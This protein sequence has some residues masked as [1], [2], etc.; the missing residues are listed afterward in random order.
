NL[1]SV[2]LAR[3]NAAAAE[4][5]AREG[6]RIRALA[7]GLVPSRRRTFEQDDWSVGRT[8]SLV[9]AALAAP[10]RFS[11]AESMLLDALHDLEAMP[12]GRRRDITDRV[13]RLIQ[14]Y[15]DRGLRGRAAAYRAAL[16]R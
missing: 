12:Y 2:Q 4:A 14:L 3:K 16:A 13:M 9:G 1:A 11:D 15:D 6:L 8:K 5:L 7:P 10:G